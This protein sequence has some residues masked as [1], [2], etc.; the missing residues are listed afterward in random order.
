MELTKDLILPKIHQEKVLTDHQPPQQGILILIG[1]PYAIHL[2]SEQL[3]RNE[4]SENYK[5]KRH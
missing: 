4:K 1:T 3:Q 5:T 2:P